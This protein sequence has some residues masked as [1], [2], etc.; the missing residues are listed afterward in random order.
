MC[1]MTTLIGSRY[2]FSF[3]WATARP[4][5]PTV[6]IMVKHASRRCMTRLLGERIGGRARRQDEW[7]LRNGV[8]E[9]NRILQSATFARRG[10]AAMYCNRLEICPIMVRSC[11]GGPQIGR[12]HV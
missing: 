8:G 3:S 9:R 4:A 7:S 2:F 11:H 10:V 1:G 12:A 5:T 6:T